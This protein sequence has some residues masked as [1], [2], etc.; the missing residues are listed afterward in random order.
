MDRS[1][2]WRLARALLL[3]TVLIAG[4]S[5]FAATL[6]DTGLSV[7]VAEA[8]VAQADK[9][10]RRPKGTNKGSDDDEDHVM[11]GQVLEIDT[12]KEPPELIV[13]S[14]DG[15]AVIRV[16]KTDEIAINGVR[17]GDH[18]QAKGEKQ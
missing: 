16:L 7:R 8:T 2:P 18:I 1:T 12:L 10:D 3:G 5:T 14:V 15:Q 6:P 4:T 13:A 11:N 9:E 17:L